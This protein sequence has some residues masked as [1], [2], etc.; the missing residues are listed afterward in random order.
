MDA[1]SFSE[2]EL[3]R[4]LAAH[5]NERGIDLADPAAAL[6][7]VESLRVMA[8]TAASNPIVRYG[9]HAEALFGWTVDVLGKCPLVQRLHAD[10]SVLLDGA[11]SPGADFLL[12]SQDGERMTVEVKNCAAARTGLPAKIFKRS[13]LDGLRRYAVTLQARPMLAI[14]WAGWG[15]WTLLD[16]EFLLASSDSARVCIPMG[17][18]LAESE[19]SLLGDRM[20]TARTEEMLFRL[21]VDILDSEPS[22]TGEEL[23]FRITAVDLL[24]GSQ[25]IDVKQ[26]Q[27]VAWFLMMF[28]GIEPADVFVRE[29]DGAG[30][31][32]F[33]FDGTPESGGVGFGFLASMLAR[34][35][36]TRSVGEGGDI[37]ALPSPALDAGHPAR[38]LAAGFQGKQI[39]FGYGMLQPRRGERG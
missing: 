2:S 16:V 21:C 22:E 17:E 8:S 7:L 37:V 6:G 4:L 23:S 29:S 30:R 12:V 31:I 3:F 10:G 9:V 32:E 15:I 18:A 14:Y 13:Y 5:A 19:M 36:M 34:L 20:V 33:V 39:S 27:R 24:F 26:E 11:S 1:G 28:G 38:H 25:V 35:F